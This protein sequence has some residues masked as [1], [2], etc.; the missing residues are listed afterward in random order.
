MTSIELVQAIMVDLNKLT[1]TSVKD[2]EIGVGIA[3]ALITLKR[4]LENDEKARQKAQEDLLAEAR[5]KR[6]QQLQEAAEKGQEVIGGETVRIN[7]DGS[8][9][10][11]IP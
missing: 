8:T 3:K 1:L 2:W 11:I 7:A 10:V 4:G 9:E 6:Q 5:E